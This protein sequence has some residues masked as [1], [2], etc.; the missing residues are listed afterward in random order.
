MPRL[1]GVNGLWAAYP[2]ADA[3]SLILTLIWTGIE[4]RELGIPFSLRRI[5]S[6]QPNV[7]NTR[8][9]PVKGTGGDSGT[10]N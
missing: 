3:F 2:V 8:V 4:F 9:E 6:G 7:A 5:L 1:F 10:E